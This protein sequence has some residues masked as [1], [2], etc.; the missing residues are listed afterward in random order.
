MT[1]EEAI[2]PTATADYLRDLESVDAGAAI[3]ANL[4][5]NPTHGDLRRM[6]EDDHARIAALAASTADEQ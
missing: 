4:P 1:I 6:V 2:D 5:E 3:L